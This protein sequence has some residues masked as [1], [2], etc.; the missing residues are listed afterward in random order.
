[1]DIRL[2]DATLRFRINAFGQVGEARV[3]LIGR[4]NVANSLAAVAVARSQ[5]VSLETAT[6]ALSTFPGVPGRLERIECGQ[7]FRVFV[8]IASTPAALENVLQAL[9]PATR[10]RLWAVFGAAGGRDL[11]R[12]AGMGEVAARL[13]DRA[14]ITNEDPR[15]ED[16]EA[17]IGAITAGMAAAG[18]R[19][20][21]DFVRIPD[22]RA[23]IAYAFE[24]AEPGDAVLLAGKATETTMIFGSEAVPWDE[25]GTARELLGQS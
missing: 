11:A 2:E 21:S 10:G 23:A 5:G 24:N 4:F 19:E 6:T 13:A 9:R 17:I 18:K 12:R 7:P 25:R 8:D 3:P 22:R 16:P 20:G 15:D 14:V 1:M